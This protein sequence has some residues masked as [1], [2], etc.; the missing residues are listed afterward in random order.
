MDKFVDTDHSYLDT[1]NTSH[2]V[3]FA[4]FA[5][6]LLMVL[7]VVWVNMLNNLT[8]EIHRA[9]GVFNILPTYVLSSNADFIKNMRQASVFT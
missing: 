7:I 9:K 2:D 5:V 3:K 1:V 6:L 8:A 4:L